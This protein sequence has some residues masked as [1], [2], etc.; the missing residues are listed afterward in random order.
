[1]VKYA[2]SID[3]VLPKFMEF[4]GDAAVV[5]HNASFDCS[6]I[7]KNCKDLDLPLMQ[8]YLIQ[9]KYVDFYIQN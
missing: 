8:L 5:A 2:D 7:E 1:M 6:F 4:I 3:F 9:Y